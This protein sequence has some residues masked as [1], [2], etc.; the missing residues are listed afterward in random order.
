MPSRHQI[1]STMTWCVRH[2][3]LS[4]R[5]AQP[6]YSLTAHG[7]HRSPS[8]GKMV[9]P[10]SYRFCHIAGCVQE[11][12]S[13][14]TGAKGAHGSCPFHTFERELEREGERETVA[15][16]TSCVK[17]VC[18]VDGCNEM[19]VVRCSDSKTRM[20]GEKGKEQPIGDHLTCE[21]HTNLLK[22]GCGHNKAFNDVFCCPPCTE[23]RA[24]PPPVRLF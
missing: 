13:A 10:N 2:P 14:C 15:F 22:G 20:V 23:A 8:E 1:W 24:P 17:E 7:A 11:A 19:G 18:A 3:K 5:P 12:E 4:T 9:H 6:S 16:C 21:K